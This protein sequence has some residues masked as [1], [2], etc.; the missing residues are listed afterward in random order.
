MKLSE[1]R[2]NPNNPRV[3]RDDKFQKLK[4]SIGDF[5][6]M[7]ELRPIVV[8]DE[9]VILGGNMRF[10]A[11]QDIYGK[12]GEIPDEWVKRAADLTE[13]E[14]RQ[15]VIKDNAAFGEWDWD[16][17]ANEWDAEE[18]AE[19]GID[20]PSEFAVNADD[21][22]TEF[23]L[24]SGEKSDICTISF[25]LQTKQRDVVN[26]AITD[27]KHLEEFK[28]IETFGNSNKNGNALYL[29]IQQW[30]DARK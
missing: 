4:K 26:Q 17:L 29:I 30:A 28:Y 15:F 9:G 18:L 1:I 11:L 3:L 24:P 6:K 21:Y 22:G 25:L 12:N 7:M 2:P 16:M 13:D 23:E 5:P 8:D 20:A 10:R 19:W 27:A 14:K